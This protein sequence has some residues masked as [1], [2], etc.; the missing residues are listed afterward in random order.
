MS[1]FAASARSLVPDLVLAGAS[2][3][4]RPARAVAFWFAIALP[5]LNLGL[6]LRGLTDPSETFAFLV[7][8][9]VNVVALLVGHPYRSG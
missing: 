4:T 9:A 2:T 3:V 5:F 1:E 6:L 8:L 7:L